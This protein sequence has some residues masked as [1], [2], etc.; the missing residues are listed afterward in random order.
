M[1]QENFDRKL[2]AAYNEC[3][4]KKLATELAFLGLTEQD[5]VEKIHNSTVAGSMSAVFIL[6]LHSATRDSIRERKEKILL[7][8]AF[9]N[10]KEYKKYI[11][12]M[13]DEE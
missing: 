7:N 5:F 9:K 8:E 12:T 3:P 11:K 6:K 10:T 13:F 1:K 2:E 4:I